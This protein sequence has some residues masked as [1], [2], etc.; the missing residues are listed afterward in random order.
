MGV[1][2][3]S[4][5]LSV[6]EGLAGERIFERSVKFGEGGWT[7]S[8]R[9]LVSV[10]AAGLDAD[11]IRAVARQLGAPADPP[12][13]A[14]LPR[15]AAVHFGADGPIGKCYLEFTPATAPEPDLV[16]LAAKWKGAAMTQDIY[17]DASAL[18]HPVKVARVKQGLGRIAT[19]PVADAVAALLEVARDGDPDGEAVLLRVSDGQGGRLSWDIG[20]ADAG[21]SVEAMRPLLE[22]LLAAL[23]VSWVWV[24]TEAGPELLGPVAL[25]RD[26]KGLPFVTL[27][28]GARA[29]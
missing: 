13:L 10:P 22:P 14:H 18:P 11:R 27:Y 1:S 26:R 9:G 12:L 25:G 4:R 8:D 16:F 15:A 23:G 24:L 19:G 5:L 7:W 2:A 3:V 6:T 29:A 28:H 17:H 21:R 20:L